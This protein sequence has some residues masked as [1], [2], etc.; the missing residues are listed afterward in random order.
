MRKIATCCAI[1]VFPIVTSELSAQPVSNS[2]FKD[3]TIKVIIGN[4][5]GGTY[6][7]YGRLVARHFGRFL[8]GAPTVVPEN[9]PGAGTIRAANYLYSAAP[10]DGTAIGIVAETVVVEQAIGNPAVAYDAARYTWLGRIVSSSGVHIML[11][12]SKVK[13]LEDAKL[14]EAVLAGTGA[15]NVAETV[16]K[17]MNAL[18]GTKFKIVSGYRSAND[19]LLA[20]ERNEVEGTAV[21]WIGFKASK[22]DWVSSKKIN[23][24]FQYLPTMSPD[25]PSA[26]S[27]GDIGDTPEAKQIFQLYGSMATIGRAIFAPPDLSKEVGSALRTAFSAMMKDENVRNEVLKLGAEVDFASG[28][29]LQKSISHTLNIPPETKTLVKTLIDKTR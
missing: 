28:E 21:N 11:S 27:L 25:L 18:L 22:P 6:D 20:M 14:H 9:M 17:L 2:N 16:P 19:A 29:D 15:G 23:V 1:V 13:T 8:L 3:K 26:P 12:S 24:I 4:D 5:P 10:K 7:F